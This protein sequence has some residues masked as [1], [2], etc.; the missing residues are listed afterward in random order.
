MTQ[1]I[2]IGHGRM[3]MKVMTDKETGKPALCFWVGDHGQDA[4]D[5]IDGWTPPEEAPDLAFVPT[6]TSPGDDWKAC[7]AIVLL[8]MSLAGAVAVEA[9]ACEE[10]L[11][12]GEGEE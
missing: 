7:E 6:G 3:A 11:E 1:R 4:G 9:A 8:V 10:R 2:E 5:L 12:A